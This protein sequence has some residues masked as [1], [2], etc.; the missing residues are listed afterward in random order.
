MLR[1]YDVLHFA[2]HCAYDCADPMNS[3]WVFHEKGKE[4]LT[5]RELTRIDRIPKF[6]FSN[7][8]ES[9]VM[10][11]KPEARNSDLAPGFTESFF[12]RGV[13]NFVCTAWPVSDVAAREF[14]SRLYQG[15]LGIRPR[16]MRNPLWPIFLK[17]V[18]PIS[19]QCMWQ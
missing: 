8:C 17:V 15:L 6:V 2:G 13:A 4:R 3:G 16:E 18:L 19:K 5:A 11:G 9:G 14:A 7:A 12:V 1:S 10:R